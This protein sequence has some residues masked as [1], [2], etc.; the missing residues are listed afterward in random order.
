M[1]CSTWG[2]LCRTRACFDQIERRLQILMHRQAGQR[3]VQVA[4]PLLTRVDCYDLLD[5]GNAMQNPR[6]FRSDRA[7]PADF[8]ASPS[9]AA[10]GAGRGAAPDEGRLL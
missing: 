5:L 3:L 8:D 7:P 1:T 2:M 6:V 10:L 9:W 4:E